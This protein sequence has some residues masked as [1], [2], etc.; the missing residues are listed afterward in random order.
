MPDG[1]GKSPIDGQDIDLI[2]VIFGSEH[3]R[4]ASALRGLLMHTKG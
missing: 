3:S 2:F 1:K 4:K